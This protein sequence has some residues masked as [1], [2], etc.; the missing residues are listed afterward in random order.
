MIKRPFTQD[1]YQLKYSHAH[2]F[3]ITAHIITMTNTTIPT[4]SH[5]R[6]HSEFSLSDGTIR[7]KQLAKLVKNAG[8]DSVALTDINNVYGLIKFYKS[9]KAEGLKPILGAE[10]WVRSHAGLHKL[11]LLCQNNQ[12]YTH[13]CEIIGEAFLHGQI[14]HKTAVN[15]DDLKRRTEGLIALSAAQEGLIG[16]RLISGQIDAAQQTLT[17]YKELFHQQF[18]I[19]IQRLG[20]EGEGIYIDRALQLAS[21]TQTPAVATNHVCFPEADDFYAHEARVCINQGNLLADDNRPKEYVENQY[22]K[23]PT[24]MQDLFGDYPQLLEN[25]HR[26]AQ[27]CNVTLDLGN[28]YLPAFENDLGLSESDYLVKMSQDGLEERLLQLFKTP[29]KIAEVRQAY[30]ERLA[31]EIGTINQMGFPGYFLIVADF[32]QWSKDNDIPV[33]PGRG[34]GAGSL[35]A[36]ALKI[37][38]LDPLAYD[39]LF[40]RFLNPERVSMPDFD[41]DFCMEKRDLVIDYV[42]QKYGRDKVSQIATHGTMA[43]KAVVRDVGRVLGNGYGFVD[44]I[45][46]LIPF[47]I[48]MTLTKA[49]EVEPDLKKRYDTEDEVKALLD[50]ALSLEGM[51]RNVGKHAGGV[52]IAPSKLTDF[53][54]LYC[55][56]DGKGVIVQYDKDDI[57]SVGLVKFDFLGL[58]TLTIIDWA[59]KTLNKKRAEQGEP[60]VN[61]MEIPLDDP[62]AY[63]ILKTCQTTAVF[64]LESS[65]MK[66]LIERLQPDCF[67]DIIA[68]VALFRPG[69]LGSGMVDD[70]INVK[71][72]RQAAEYP[73]P[74]LEPILKSTY[75][76]ILYQEQVM[77]IAQVLASYSLGQA[78]MLRRAMGKKKPEEMKKQGEMFMEGAVKNGHDAEKAKYIFEL[79]EK[80][81]GYG[82]NKSHSAAYALLA[83]QTAWLKAHYPQAFM[84]AVLSA[85][86][87]N[88]S[89]V[90]TLIEECRNM[91]IG[92]K[93]P[94]LNESAY[95]FTVND[96]NE[97]VYGLGAVK[98]AGEA[99][100]ETLIAYREQHGQVQNIEEFFLTADFSKLNKR[101]L[102]ALITAGVFDD[103]E[104][105]RRY[106]LE[107]LPS[108][109]KLAEQTSKN[110][111]SGQSDLFGMGSV[112]AAPVAMP[113]FGDKDKTWAPQEQLQYE[114]SSL[115]L[116]LTGH[117]ID[118]Y[119]AELMD[120]LGGNTLADTLQR[121]SE[122]MPNDDGK[123]N[124]FAR[125]GK[126]VWVAGL[127]MDMRVRPLKSGNGKMAFVTIDD[128]SART[129]VSFFAKSFEANNEVL[130]VDEI[131]IIKGRASHDDFSGGMKISADHAFPLSQ[132]GELFG[133]AIQIT[134]DEQMK[135]NDIDAVIATLQNHCGDT[136]GVDVYMH[137]KGNAAEGK[138][139]LPSSHKL[140]LQDE[141]YQELL[142]VCGKSRLAL[143][144]NLSRWQ[145]PMAESDKANDS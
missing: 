17:S 145:A 97:I 9:A 51:A 16:E 50:L 134:L 34:S 109:L 38:D 93:N 141:C 140:S 28:S 88:T 2:L 126:R 78:D 122:S 67:D 131:L 128:R 73:L 44:G 35:V 123:D 6:V 117:P 31:F 76:V 77:Q 86:M 96:N 19:E 48:G 36:Y 101:V 62:A 23:S 139:R 39:L 40:E 10:V 90:V 103:L 87:D 65:G 33:G 13:L 127:V 49:L 125:R 18:Y 119:K 75:G 11:V 130:K 29:E 72:G 32:I 108:F 89:K 56:D 22:L 129:E 41:V 111:Q 95:Q 107:N 24:E 46:K 52:V 94:A 138:L 61:I 100:L 21:D 1:D 4:F 120:I 114:K 80:F 106:L 43:A 68:L 20:K 104:P 124:K 26:I 47:E 132:A 121:V 42:A 60:A 142:A 112:S 54:A 58:R 98:G 79:M 105:N 63:D 135:A 91:G 84:A 57:E 137:V 85:D 30:D 69:P 82:F 7:I 110:Q 64:Q 53:S 55:E 144:Y 102:E 99:A 37:T 136:N 66:N 12:G 14:E 74:E 15:F 133:E 25:A 3:P 113:I 8:Y 92:I 116:Y 70:F 143:R 45:A 83:Y 115:G 118:S 5:L 27:K 71:H 59:L 81:A